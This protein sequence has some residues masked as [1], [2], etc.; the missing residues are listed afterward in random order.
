VADD[1]KSF[2]AL[3]YVFLQQDG[4]F[5]RCHSLGLE[6]FGLY[7]VAEPFPFTVRRVEGENLA[8]ATRMQFGK[9]LVVQRYRTRTDA[10]LSGIRRLC[11]ITK[12]PKAQRAKE[13]HA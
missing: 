5:Y 8:W 3:G 13:T 9:N 2:T 6:I 11:G 4:G 10:A 12:A 1:P 7:G